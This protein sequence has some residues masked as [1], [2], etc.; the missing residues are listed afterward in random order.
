MSI[1]KSARR[2]ADLSK[3]TFPRISHCFFHMLML[4]YHQKAWL[5][6]M[7]TL[8]VYLYT[9]IRLYFID[10]VIQ[11]IYTD[12]RNRSRGLKTPPTIVGSFYFFYIYNWN[13]QISK[14]IYFQAFII[15]LMCSFLPFLYSF[16]IFPF[17]C[18]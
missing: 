2:Q 14:P 12:F 5:P 15:F 7:L 13:H 16:P 17:S 6:P 10:Y 1:G 18:L 9:P 4:H 11:V 3:Q 8:D